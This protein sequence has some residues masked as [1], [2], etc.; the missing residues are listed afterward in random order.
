MSIF[1]ETE[2]RNE[3]ES[4]EIE[5]LRRSEKVF[6]IRL[7][8]VLLE[9]G[10]KKSEF[11]GRIGIAPNTLSGYL[12]GSHQPD[13]DT[14]ILICDV[15]GLSSDYMLGRSDNPNIDNTHSPNEEAMLSYYRN[16]TK[17]SQ[18][19]LLG[20][21]RGILRT[22]DRYRNEHTNTNPNH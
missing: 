17:K 11:A 18:H 20:E 4:N 14:L 1:K 8:Q 9:R 15:L 6:Q 7:E 22:E 12:N 16:L 19:E 2:N 21:A 13:M 10:I 3:E 5:K